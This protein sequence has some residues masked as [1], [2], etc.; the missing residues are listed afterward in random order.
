MIAEDT[1]FF[2]RPLR[3]IALLASFRQ[4]A[5]PYSTVK[6]TML[7]LYIRLFDLRHSSPSSQKQ[8]KIVESMNVPF[9]AHKQSRIA[10]QNAA[11]H[12]DHLKTN[13]SLHRRFVL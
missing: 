10:H 2:P 7:L 12:S 13:Y 11:Q 3:A 8:Q 6:I 9:T 1:F 5:I 4:D